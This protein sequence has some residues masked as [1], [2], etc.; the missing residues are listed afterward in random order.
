M[1]IRKKILAL[2]VLGLFAIAQGAFA[3]NQTSGAAFSSAAISAPL[4]GVLQGRW[5]LWTEL[6][7]R[8]GVW[9]LKIVDGKTG[10]AVLD[11]SSVL[12]GC[13][14]EGLPVKF[15][16]DGDNL[17]ILETP[18]NLPRVDCPDPFS[19][20]LNRIGPKK[21]EGTARRSSLSFMVTLE[22]Q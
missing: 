13:S 9:T 4:S 21:F 14:I 10:T 15:Q 18:L 5:S 11:Y 8:V 12:V 16:Y 17:S 22:E 6:R 3:Q 7:L 2:L 1:D 20:T 19:A